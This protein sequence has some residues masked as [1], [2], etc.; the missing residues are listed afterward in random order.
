M[1]TVDVAQANPYAVT[2][3]EIALPTDP[4][5][6]TNEPLLAAD[7]RTNVGGRLWSP[8]T[9][10]VYTDRIELK[11][12]F[13]SFTIPIAK[14]RLLRSG[15][16]RFGRHL[17]IIHDEQIVPETIHFI[18][19]FPG[20]WY[21]VLETLGIP[22]E[23]ATELRQSK[24]L[25]HRSSVW[26]SNAEGAFWLLWIALIFVGGIVAGLINFFHGLLE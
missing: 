24:Q 8:C 25:Y 6:V 20:K 13:Q 10:T 23:D 2:T 14:V 9:H 3:T 21:D 4:E 19:L 16:K 17:E 1:S 22:T 7:V 12:L 11:F 15:G 5:S 26:V 18:P